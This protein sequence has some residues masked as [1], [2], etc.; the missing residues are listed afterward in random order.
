MANLEKG[1]LLWQFHNTF[2]MYL[3]RITAATASTP[4]GVAACLGSSTSGKDG[5]VLV[6]DKCRGRLSV[7]FVCPYR[8]CSTTGSRTGGEVHRLLPQVSIR[9]AD[10]VL[11]VLRGP[12]PLQRHH[13]V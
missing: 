4:P 6:R 13:A 10:R 11:R 5:I 9:H 1:D 2:H 3:P 7:C 12:H 8:R